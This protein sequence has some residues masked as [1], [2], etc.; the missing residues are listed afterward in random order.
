[1]PVKIH[2]DDDNK[3]EDR[4]RYDLT[5]LT[6]RTRT[7]SDEDEM[8]R[9]QKKKKETGADDRNHARL[10][11]EEEVSDSMGDDYDVTSLNWDNLSRALKKR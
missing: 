8:P 4:Q 9:P 3:D 1:L 7:S 2:R 5:T 6:K 10:G 11:L